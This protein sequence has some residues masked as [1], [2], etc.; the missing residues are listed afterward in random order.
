MKRNL[1]SL[2]IALLL[3]AFPA[4]AEVLQM[5]LSIFGMD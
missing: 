2:S 3:A 5:D 1:L 4:A